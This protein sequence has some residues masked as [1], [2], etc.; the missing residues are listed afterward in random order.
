MGAAKCWPMIRK[1]LSSIFLGISCL[2][3]KMIPAISC[4]TRWDMS[5]PLWPRVKKQSKQWK[6]PGL[7]SP[8]KY[9][10]FIDWF[11]WARSNDKRCILC[12][13][14]QEI[15]RKRRGK[16]TRGV[17]LL[18]DNA[19]AH[20]SQ[21]TMTAATECGFEILPHPHIFSWYGSFCLL[22]VAKTEIPIFVVH[23]KEAMKA[24]QR[25]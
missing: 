21:V 24:S 20:M 25:Q 16:L 7:P 12:R 23:S 10:G 2:A 17:L 22:S 14:R 19:L 1:G 3:M 5:S 6:H 15:A 13:L 8:K 9:K 18:Q 4:N 11:S